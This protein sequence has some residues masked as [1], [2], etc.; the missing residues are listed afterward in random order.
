MKLTTNLIGMAI[1][2]N[3]W[4]AIFTMLPI[5]PLDGSNVF[6]ASRLLYA[7]AFGCIVGYALLVLVL[8]FY[9]LI[10]VI[11][12]GIIFWFATY[13]VMEKAG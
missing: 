1:S 6:F 13:Q 11:L 4:L 8:G 5:P 3:I 10:F 2:L 7:F 9:S 12:M